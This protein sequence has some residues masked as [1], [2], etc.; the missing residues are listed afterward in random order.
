MPLSS[1]KIF[2]R[3][4]IFHAFVVVSRQQRSPLARKEL[5]KLIFLCA[6]VY[7]KGQSVSNLYRQLSMELSIYLDQF[8]I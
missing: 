8:K 5:I 1:L 4:V 3:W 7:I 6:H 2:A